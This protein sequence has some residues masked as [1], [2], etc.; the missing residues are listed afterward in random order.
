MSGADDMP[1]NTLAEKMENLRQALTPE[2]Q[3]PLS[4]AAVATAIAAAAGDD[5][6]INENTLY[7]LRTGR[8]D[9]PSMRT[10]SAIAKHY[11][12]LTDY[13]DPH[14]SWDP[15][16]LR[17][18]TAALARV[19]VRG[20]VLRLATLPEDKVTALGRLLDAS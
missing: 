9:N 17:L 8:I 19:E 16:E 6:A 12:V 4:D 10:L 2:G 15:C 14:A 5:P 1:R 20:V 13:F 3:R 11:E 7:R 18:V